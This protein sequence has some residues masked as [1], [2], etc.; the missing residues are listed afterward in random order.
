MTWRLRCASCGE[1][2]PPHPL[3][4][5]GRCGTPL[6]IDLEVIGLSSRELRSRFEGRPRGVWR[7]KELLPELG[8][9]PPSLGEGGTFLQRAE[10]LGESLGLRNLYLKNE[11]TNPTGSFL[12]RGA[13]VEVA[14][15]LS[16]GAGL[17]ACVARG[18]LAASIAAYAVKAG[19]PCRV[20]ALPGAEQGKLL[21]ALAYD[22]EVVFVGRR[23]EAEGLAE[24]EGAYLVEPSNPLLIEGLKTCVLEVLEELG[25]EAPDA[26]FLPVGSGGHMTATWKAVREAE[27]LGL[28][29]GE[30]PRMFGAQTA[31]CAPLVEAYKSGSTRV[32]RAE[33]CA[34]GFPDIADPEPELGA[35]ALQ[36]IRESRG[37]AVAVEDSEV[38][39]AVKLLAKTEGILAEPAAATALA[40]LKRVVEEGAIDRDQR[41]LYIVTGSG[42]K[43]P[44]SLR[45]VSN[46]RTPAGPKVGAT[47]LKILHVLLDGPLH[48]YGIR[49]ELI[50]RFGLDI[51]L[52][53]VYQHLREL[54]GMGL[55]ASK[56]LERGLGR[57]VVRRY[58]LTPRGKELLERFSR[59]P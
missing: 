45:S 18:N 11:T 1:E 24:E 32:G 39:E 28:L 7:Y 43:D 53:T 4:R 50:S 35:Q 36:A 55:V 14:G 52:P 49:R 3:K 30:L 25:W 23:E 56:P 58:L 37:A 27:G 12:D 26:I 31:G 22:A 16:W 57:R 8:V 6:L 15:A 33:R 20:Y 9:E 46:V 47:K 21:Q 42:L 59:E 13:V 38:L 10:R 54:L 41:I 29:R 34:A 40:A 19:L 2:Y 51:K 48:G 17:L 44:I 5:C